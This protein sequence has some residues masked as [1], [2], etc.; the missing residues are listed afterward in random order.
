M[1]HSESS[2]KE[3]RDLATGQIKGV[4][5]REKTDGSVDLAR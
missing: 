2:S 5:S 1:I 3:I 4:K